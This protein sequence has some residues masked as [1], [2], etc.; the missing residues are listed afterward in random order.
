[1]PTK[2][3]EYAVEGIPTIA[4]KTTAIAAYFEE[5]MVQFFAPGSV[6]DLARCILLLYRE[7]EHRAALAK[8]ILSFN[9][10]YNWQDA[11]TAYVEGVE[12]LC[13]KRTRA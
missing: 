10:R 4:A 11:S 5:G 6:D 12:K 7:P 9:A 8:G 3:M 2:L 13:L 1:M